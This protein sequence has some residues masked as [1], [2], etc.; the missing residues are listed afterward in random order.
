MPVEPVTRVLLCL[1]VVLLFAYLGLYTGIVATVSRRLGLWTAPLVWVLLEFVI[2]KTQIAFP[3]NLLGYS[4]VPYVPFIQPAAL[5]GVYLISAWLV[6]VNL[7]IYRLV[8]STRRLAY[9][10]ALLA[11]FIV[12][13]VI[14]RL[15]I[16]PNKPWF[17]VAILQPNVS[18][19]DKGDWNAR[20]RIQAD[21]VRLTCEAARSKP[22]LIIYPETATLVDVTRSNTIGKTIRSLVDSIG[23]EVVTGTPLHDIPHNTWHNGAVLLEP[24]QDSVRQRHYKMRLV[25]F[26][27]KIPYSDEIPLLG[28]I[29]G[30]ADMGNWDRGWEYNVFLWTKGTLSCLVCFEAIFP[31]LVREFTRRGSELLVVVTNDGWFGKLPGSSQHADLAIMRTVENGVPMV[32]SAN[33][34]ISFIA[35]P[36]GRVLKKTGLFTQTVLEGTVPRPLKP[37][38][39]RRFRDWFIILCLAGIAAAVICKLVRFYRKPS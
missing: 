28:R 21:L 19:F 25:P 33:N 30:T 18:P 34:G 27:E 31:D 16:R 29:I 12:P 11:A 1:G 23:I 15:N 7:L 22:D 20:E 5:G 26:S 4:M 2:T 32:R 13:L 6:L 3:W 39:Y 10:A 8:F 35:D 24:G 36:Y 38:P 9:G 17:N 37:T 14:A